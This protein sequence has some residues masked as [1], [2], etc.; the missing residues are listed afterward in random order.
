[1]LQPL[2]LTGGTF[3]DDLVSP[4]Q[5]QQAGFGVDEKKNPSRKAVSSKGCFKTH[6]NIHNDAN[7][8][9][10]LIF[11]AVPTHPICDSKTGCTSE[12]DDAHEFGEFIHIDDDKDDFKSNLADDLCCT[13]EPTGPSDDFDGC[14]IEEASYL[15]PRCARPPTGDSTNGAEIKFEQDKDLLGAVDK[16]MCNLDEPS[17][18]SSNLNHDPIELIRQHVARHRWARSAAPRRCRSWSPPRL[19]RIR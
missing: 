1:M 19:G 8:I 9:V 5:R 17:I 15:S 12:D 3:G 14:E 13:S 11:P 7:A 2:N 16:Q 6:M 10:A 18:A 4:L